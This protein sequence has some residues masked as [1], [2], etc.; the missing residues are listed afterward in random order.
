MHASAQLFW[1]THSDVSSSGSDYLSCH[2]WKGFSRR[3]RAWSWG[4]EN[5]WQA[6]TQETIILKEGFSWNLNYICINS[7]WHTY[8]CDKNTQTNK[9]NPKTNTKRGIWEF[10]PFCMRIVFEL[11]YIKLNF[12]QKTYMTKD[13]ILKFSVCISRVDCRFKCLCPVWDWHFHA[14]S[15]TL[16]SVLLLVTNGQLYWSWGKCDSLQI[17]HLGKCHLKGCF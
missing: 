10:Y 9:K 16:F 11:H 7:K 17:T 3:Q 6:K 4:L 5:L 8:E 12:G 2:L 13:H 14:Y 15:R 1:L